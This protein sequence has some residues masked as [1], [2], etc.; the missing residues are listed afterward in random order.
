MLEEI[1]KSNSLNILYSD[2][3]HESYLLFMVYLKSGLTFILILK[4]TFSLTFHRTGIF[5]VIKLQ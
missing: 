1:D 2:T 3:L 4:F 5:N